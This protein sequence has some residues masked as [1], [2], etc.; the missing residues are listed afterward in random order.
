MKDDGFTTPILV[1]EQTM[2]IVDGEH[3]WTGAIVLAWLNKNHPLGKDEFWPEKLITESREKRLDLL[4]EVDPIIPIV[5]TPMTPE[6]MRVATLRHNRARGEEDVELA[7]EVLRDLQQL[8]ALE[9]AKDELML[10]DETLKRLMEDVSASD[11][12]GE[13][14]FGEAWDPSD[15]GDEGGEDGVGGTEADTSETGTQANSE[16]AS[17]LRRERLERVR[18][19]KNEEERKRAVEETKIFRL[20]LVFSGEEAETITSVLG[21]RPAVRLLEL[22]REHLNE[23]E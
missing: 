19:A 9:W 16:A 18:A 23:E 21:D 8:G 2:E 7:A 22:C 13:D 20:N 11:A 12:L 15:T 6:Q 10:D 4:S 14:E 3:R 5:K 17:R 1:Q